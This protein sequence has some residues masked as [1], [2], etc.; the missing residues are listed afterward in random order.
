MK[1]FAYSHQLD[2]PS[3]SLLLMVA[4]PDPHPLGDGAT[5]L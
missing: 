1:L 5:T 3:V 4:L 2:V